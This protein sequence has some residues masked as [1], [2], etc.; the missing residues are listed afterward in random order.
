MLHDNFGVESQH[1]I[2]GVL[3]TFNRHTINRL[4]SQFNS[5][6]KVTQVTQMT[7]GGGGGTNDLSMNDTENTGDCEREKDNPPYPI[8]SLASLAS[9]AT[10]KICGE[11][12]DPEPY[13]QKIH[14]CEGPEL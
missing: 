10:C 12:L 14:K 8:A 9:P 11:V 2:K 4:R 1:T 3:Y 13:W 6:I 5:K 7:Q